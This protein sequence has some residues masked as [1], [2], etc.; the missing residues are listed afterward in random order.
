L[1]DDAVDV[2]FALSRKHRKFLIEQYSKQLI[3]KPKLKSDEQRLLRLAEIMGR[4]LVDRYRRAYLLRRSSFTGIYEAIAP[5]ANA[6]A[7]ATRLQSRY[8]G[9]DKG[10]EPD[11]ESDEPPKLN[12]LATLADGSYVIDFVSRSK[13]RLLAVDYAFVNG[14]TIVH[15]SIFLRPMANVT[16]VEGKNEESR[17]QLFNEFCKAVDVK[18]DSFALRAFDRESQWQALKSALGAQVGGHA[19][20]QRGYREPAAYSMHAAKGEGLDD[21]AKWKSLQIPHSGARELAFNFVLPHEIDG[22]PELVIYY[23]KLETGQIK[24]LSE[25]SEYALRKV[26]DEYIKIARLP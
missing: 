8:P 12:R 5:L 26:C 7:L 2:V 10:L 17:D 15:H 13:E 24:F 25:I 9:V 21:L 14:S 6:D 18:R 19:G 16:L 11:V 3:T 23:L 4:N 22:Y 1:S 20:T